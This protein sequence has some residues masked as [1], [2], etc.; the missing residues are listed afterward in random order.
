M[1]KY[2]IFWKCFIP[3]NGYMKAVIY[4]GSTTGTCEDLAN[5]LGHMD[6]MEPMCKTDYLMRLASPLL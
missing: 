6:L 5:R 4:Y 3:R 2:C 1:N